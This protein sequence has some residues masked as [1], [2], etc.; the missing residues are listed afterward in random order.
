MARHL[1]DRNDDTDVNRD[2]ET[3]AQTG[4]DME[5]EDAQTEAAL[6]R[7]EL[8]REREATARRS[9]GGINWGACFYGWLVALAVTVLLGGIASAVAAGSGVDLNLH[10]IARSLTIGAAI[11]LAV[12]MLIGY[13]AGGYVAGRMTR[14]DGA[15]QGVG[16]W[17]VALVVMAIA[18]GVGAVFGS[19][20]NVM[21][22]INLPSVGFS[23]HQ[24]GWAAL[25]AGVVALLLML[26][27]AVLGG[28]TGHRYH[29]R[30]DSLVGYR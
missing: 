29:D 1:V 6:S 24:L 25:A 18:G 27:G 3:D 12:V 17:V 23:S 5:T 28:R 16:V 8:L 2:M 15:L 11:T 30:V 21:N 4:R 26:V 22:R 19:Q 7:E 14:F 13:F 9:F 20:Y 10:H